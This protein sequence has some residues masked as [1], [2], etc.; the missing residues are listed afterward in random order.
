MI[1]AIILNYW[2]QRLG[3]IA[4]IIKDL[5]SGTVKPDRIIVWNNDS[6]TKIEPHLGNQIC[7]NSS[8]NFH[9]LVR[10]AMGLIS[11]SDHCLFID[12]DLTVRRDTLEFLVKKSR[13]F[14]EAILGFYGKDIGLGGNHPYTSGHD[15]KD[16]DTTTEVD[17]VLGRIHFCKRTKLANAFKLETEVDLLINGVVEEDIVLSMANKIFEMESNYIF[18]N[19]VIELDEGGV[20]YHYTKNHYPRRDESLKRILNWE[21]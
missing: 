21:K 11:E 14:P 6:N 9:C 1:S 17:M 15:I 4:R 19:R 18:P 3:N 8:Y 20:G 12:D 2:P 16:V 5:N 7:I 13:L 10:Y